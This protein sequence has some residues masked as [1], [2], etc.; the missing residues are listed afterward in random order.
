MFWRRGFLLCSCLIF[1]GC[2]G[3]KDTGRRFSPNAPL[4]QDVYVWQRAWNETVQSAIRN[5]GEAFGELVVLS[6]EVH[7]KNGMPEIVAIPVDFP[8]LVQSQRPVG[9]ALRIGTYAG[10]FS[11]D[12]PAASML[13]SLTLSILTEAR[14]SGLKVQEVQL[15]F[16]CAE[17]K[18][19]GYAVWIKAIRSTVAPL[20]LTITV[21]PS[22]IGRPA[23]R[24]LISETDGYVLQVHSLEKPRDAVERFTLCDPASARRFV[25]RAAAVGKPFRVALPT[26]G[27]LVAFDQTG[28]FIGL[29]AEGPARSWPPGV[30][31]REVR[32]DPREMAS[33][34]QFWS[35]NRP[36]ELQ[37]IIWYR[38]P[39]STDALNWR[40]PTLRAIMSLRS[41]HESMRAESRRVEPGLI[42]ISLANDGELDISSRLAVEV[43]WS[44]GGGTRL[45]AADGLRGFEVADQNE[46]AL[47][48]T[49]MLFQLPSGETQVVG[50]LRFSEDREVQVEWKKS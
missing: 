39:N 22:W 49:S 42:E 26:Y 17:S 29:S 25:Q 34:V 8:T 50:W 37:G 18:L 2:S 35:A 27:Y 24:R 19:D 10:P 11:T 16:D 41:P 20:P 6:A 14:N 47:R 21:L 46:S 4:P 5:H 32:A 44:R 15:D 38:L 30:R 36:P 1:S 3:S 33:L 12:G 28:K 23:F 40:W 43:R 7:W 13:R 9:L 48:L 31:L 45:L